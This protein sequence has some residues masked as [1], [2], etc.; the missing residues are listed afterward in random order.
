MEIIQSQSVAE[1]S[2][3]N[4]REVERLVDRESDYIT[5]S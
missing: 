1:N 4:I 2:N 3:Y 5:Y